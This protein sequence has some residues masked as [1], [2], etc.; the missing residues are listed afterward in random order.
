MPHDTQYAFC[1]W[2]SSQLMKACSTNSHFCISINFWETD[3]MHKSSQFHFNS[4]T[5][6]KC[7]KTD[8]AV[9]S[10]KTRGQSQAWVCISHFFLY[11]PS[12]I[13]ILA[14][15]RILKMRI[16]AIDS[17]CNYYCDFSVGIKMQVHCFVLIHVEK[18]LFSATWQLF[19]RW[20]LPSSSSH[21]SSRQFSSLFFSP[22]TVKVSNTASSSVLKT[23]YGR[24]N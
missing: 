5:A 22:Q 18:K 12:F 10:L 7:N 8:L 3:L 23:K 11:F 19:T 6:Q 13:R 4:N 9:I 1:R 14:A 15:V 2:S 16:L 24:N 17:I 20:K 21:F